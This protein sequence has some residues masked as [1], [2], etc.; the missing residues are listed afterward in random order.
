MLR[1]M[2]SPPPSLRT[3]P[4]A[5]FGTPTSPRTSPG[6]GL[7]KALELEEDYLFNSPPELVSKLPPLL[8]PPPSAT[9]GGTGPTRNQPLQ[10]PPCEL[11]TRQL[12]FHPDLAAG[13]PA[14]AVALPGPR[15]NDRR[16][17]ESTIDLAAICSHSGVCSWKRSARRMERMLPP[18]TPSSVPAPACFF[19][20][21]VYERSAIQ[22][23]LEHS[24]TDPLTRQ[25]LLNK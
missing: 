24:T 3:P 13:V 9:G 15:A 4:R 20:H 19:M 18:C 5:A 16:A 23:H 10:Q 22:S 2:A 1:S 14:D 7:S 8:P 21:Q 12:T 17:C 6:Q 25:P 11:W